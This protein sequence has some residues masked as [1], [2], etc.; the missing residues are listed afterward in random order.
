[1]CIDL[2]LYLAQIWLDYLGT[3]C[4]TTAM[5]QLTCKPVLAWTL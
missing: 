3:I 4:S 5:V 1:M 2:P